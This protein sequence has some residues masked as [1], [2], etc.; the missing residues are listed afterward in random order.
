MSESYWRIVEPIWNTINLDS[1]EVFLE[2]Y[3]RSPR[4]AALLYAAHFCQSE[5][6]NG[7]FHQL[8]YNV[9]GVLAPEAV[10]GFR[11]IEQRRV[12]E[13]V[14]AAMDAL[15][16]PYPRDRGMRAEILAHFTPRSFDA[17]DEQ[18]FALIRTE[19]GGFEVATDKYAV[20][21]RRLGGA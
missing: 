11:A 13:T 4:D 9:T 19:A 17:L 5:V 10:D 12:A 8:F 20:R 2:T 6:C 18:F 1:V 3:S 14:Q 21:S 15:G 7:G 16:S